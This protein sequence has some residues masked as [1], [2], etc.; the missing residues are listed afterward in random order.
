MSGDISSDTTP[1]V[2]IS[3]PPSSSGSYDKV[4]LWKDDELVHESGP[5]SA[6]TSVTVNV[7][8]LR[9]DD[10]TEQR[11]TLNAVVDYPQDN[12]A[13]SYRA[14]LVDTRHEPLTRLASVSEELDVHYWRP[15]G[16][17]ISFDPLS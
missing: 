3:I 6:D 13:Q 12:E 7:V 8:D 11:V 4:Q 2:R 10:R 17:N 15:H 1:S 5:G 16:A 9:A 14:I